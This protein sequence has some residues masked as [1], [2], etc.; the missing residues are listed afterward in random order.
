M[1]QP[2]REI[3]QM[4]NAHVEEAYA[5]W[6]PVYD[7][8]FATIMAPGR[9]AAAAAAQRGAELILDVGVGTGLELPLF[10]VGVKLVGV[11]LSEPMLRRAQNRVEREKLRQVAGLCVMDATRLAFADAR[12]DAVVAPYVL[13]VVPDPPATLDELARVVKPGGEIVLVNHVGAESGPIAWAERWLGQKSAALGWRPE[14]PWSILS[15]WLL[16][17][18]DMRLVERRKIAPLGLFTLTRIG[19]LK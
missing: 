8:A 11:D 4:E 13:T 14:F 10:D 3:A 19:R 7:L 12:F 2:R 9:R 16:S 1:N 5:R 15:D 17:R 18:D 6:A